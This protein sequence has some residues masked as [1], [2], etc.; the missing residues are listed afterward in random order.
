MIYS[1]WNIATR[2]YDY[3]RGGAITGTHAG[4]PPARL[5]TPEIGATPDQIAWTLPE[6]ATHIGS[7]S[8]ARGRIASKSGGVLGDFE[9]L[10]IPSY[11]ILAGVVYAAWRVFR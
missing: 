2:Q 10:G 6:G 9:A 7:G 3:Y 5:F 8:I 4:T 1:V 11:L